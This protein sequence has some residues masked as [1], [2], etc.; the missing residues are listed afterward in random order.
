MFCSIALTFLES[1]IKSQNQ[2]QMKQ[3]TSFIKEM[4]A[5]FLILK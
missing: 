2:E 3:N 1:S 4:V 5:M